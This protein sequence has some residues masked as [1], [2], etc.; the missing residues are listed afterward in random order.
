MVMMSFEFGNQILDSRCFVELACKGSVTVAE[1][2]PRQKPRKLK[3]RA[4][5]EMK[6]II[7]DYYV[8]GVPNK[9]TAK[10]LNI[11]CLTVYRV[12]RS[13][14][15]GCTSFV[16]KDPELHPQK[17]EIQRIISLSLSIDPL[18]TSRSIQYI[19]AAQGF[20]ISEK[21]VTLWKKGL[22]VALHLKS[23]A[24]L[25]HVIPNDAMFVLEKSLE[26]PNV[27][28]ENGIIFLSY[29]QMDVHIRQVGSN[30]N[31]QGSEGS[32]R[33]VRTFSSM[34]LAICGS[35]VLFFDAICDHQVT[36]SISV[37]LEKLISKLNGSPRIFIVAS[38]FPCFD[39][40]KAKA[41]KYNH[42]VYT[43][44]YNMCH[45]HLG[46][47][48][49]YNLPRWIKQHRIINRSQ[50]ESLLA[51]PQLLFPVL[52]IRCLYYRACAVFFNPVLE[53]APNL[54]PSRG[55]SPTPLKIP[56]K[57][58]YQQAQESIK[59]GSKV[60]PHEITAILKEYEAMF[61]EIKFPVY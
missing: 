5:D 33:G 4:T 8:E 28:L 10:K 34:L 24:S 45:C 37:S 55:I 49:F 23:P 21:A 29:K 46:D 16:N 25:G 9:E 7:F 11:S 1:H 12:L 14:R 27:S 39:E 3:P 41:A 60:S 32:G 42:M 61:T 44:P 13:I 31:I 40:F 18:L 59:A 36:P 56:D 30:I 53:S 58:Y 47:I 57:A 52:E 26:C 51:Q 43:M 38:D 6:K 48:A 54:P 2:P 17:A 20:F 35:D 19:L 50:I 22:Y 15:E